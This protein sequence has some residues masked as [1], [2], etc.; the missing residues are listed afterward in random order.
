[1]LDLARGYGDFIVMSPVFFRIEHLRLA[2]ISATERHLAPFHRVSGRVHA[3][4]RS[5]YLPDEGR[6]ELK[7]CPGP[8]ERTHR[9]FPINEAL[10]GPPLLRVADALFQTKKEKTETE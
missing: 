9:R 7:R 1:V 5:G 10:E 4:M 3:E 8:K 6:P 2:F